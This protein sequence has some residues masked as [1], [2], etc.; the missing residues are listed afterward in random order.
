MR[1]SGAHAR[2]IAL[3]ALRLSVLSCLLGC[4]H[5]PSAGDAPE[6]PP[7]SDNAIADLE[8]LHRLGTYADLEYAIGVQE[9]HCEAL[10]AWN[11]RDNSPRFN[12]VACLLSLE[13]CVD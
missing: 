12:W 1:Q 10:E 7:W 13:T 6:C 4:A 2:P 5:G 3:L 11:G 9:L 8:R